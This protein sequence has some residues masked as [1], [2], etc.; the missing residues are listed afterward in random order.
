L[1]KVYII[2]YIWAVIHNTKFKENVQ[3]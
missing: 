3:E 1:L 2:L